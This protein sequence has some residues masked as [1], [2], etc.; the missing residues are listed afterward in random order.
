MK[1]SKRYILDAT[2]SLRAVYPKRLEK[3]KGKGWTAAF[4]HWKRLPIT[5]RDLLTIV[6]KI[7]DVL[8]I[9]LLKQIKTR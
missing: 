5:V 9:N 1:S 7:S 2:I 8:S 4:S 3:G 6:V